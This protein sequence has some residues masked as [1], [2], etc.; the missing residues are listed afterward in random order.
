MT[1]A[2]M[3]MMNLYSTSVDSVWYYCKVGQMNG[4]DQQRPLVTGLRS[5]PVIDTQY[6][7]MASAAELQ[8]SVGEQCR[9]SDTHSVNVSS[10]GN[11]IHF[12]IDLFQSSAVGHLPA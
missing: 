12:L 1:K 2:M 10:L 9:S 4:V 6:S 8:S 7:V 5:S 3:M 11:Y